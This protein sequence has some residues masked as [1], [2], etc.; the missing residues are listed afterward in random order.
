M[1]RA[2]I[3]DK[4]LTYFVESLMEATHFDGGYIYLL[5]EYKYILFEDTNDDIINNMRSTFKNL[6]WYDVI[7]CPDIT[8]VM[9]INKTGF[10][11]NKEAHITAPMR[12]APLIHTNMGSSLNND[13]RRSDRAV[14]CQNNVYDKRKANGWY[15]WNR[16]TYLDKNPHSDQVL[17]HHKPNSRLG[18][19][20]SYY[21]YQWKTNRDDGITWGDILEGI[22]NISSCKYSSWYELLSHIN[23]TV[24]D[25]MMLLEVKFSHL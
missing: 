4:V 3:T 16:N 10:N 11:F 13:T 17:A 14:E 5:P 21:N 9:I 25:N 8:F 19:D 1:D 20:L 7:L 12:R 22:L 6:N 24:K 18:I 15:D 23:V 2:E